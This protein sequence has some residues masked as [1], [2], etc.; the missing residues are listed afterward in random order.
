VAHLHDGLD[1][2]A[3]SIGKHNLF[4]PTADQTPEP[5]NRRVEITVS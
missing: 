2:T 1:R 4:V 3:I 5:R